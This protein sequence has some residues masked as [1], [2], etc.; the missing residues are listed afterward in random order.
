MATG[1]P[2]KMSDRRAATHT[3]VVRVADGTRRISH[4][5]LVVAAVRLL[6]APN[7]VAGLEQL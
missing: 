5:L 6:R 2:S 7:E 3:L 1:D 4:I